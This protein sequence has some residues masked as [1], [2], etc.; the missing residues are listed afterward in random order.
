MKCTGCNSPMKYSGGENKNDF[1]CSAPATCP[2]WNDIGYYP[3]VSVRENWWFSFSYNLPFKHN[4]SW[5]CVQGPIVEE[6]SYECNENG[7][8]IDIGYQQENLTVFSRLEQHNN[9][10]FLSLGYPKDTVSTPILTIPYMALPVNND[11]TGEFNK[12]INHKDFKKYLL[13]HDNTIKMR[14]RRF[15]DFWIIG[16]GI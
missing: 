14:Q 9:Y 2:C 5:Y 6:Y 16:R 12:L 11:F 7:D 15:D 4:D 3:H 10:G 8:L 1:S 13:T